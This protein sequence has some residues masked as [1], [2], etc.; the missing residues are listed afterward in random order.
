MPRFT[1][2]TALACSHEAV[3]NPQIRQIRQ[4]RR[5]VELSGTFSP[6][7]MTIMHDLLDGKAGWSSTCQAFEHMLTL[8]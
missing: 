1:A 5:K 8:S 6:S 7:Q 2:M 4:T 3:S